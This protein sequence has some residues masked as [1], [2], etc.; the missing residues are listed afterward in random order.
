MRTLLIVADDQTNVH[1]LVDRLQKFGSGFRFRL[2]TADPRVARSWRQKGLEVMIGDPT[3]LL[4]VAQ[5]LVDVEMWY[6]AVSDHV[7]RSWLKAALWVQAHF[8]RPLQ[9]LVIAAVPFAPALTQQ[10]RQNGLQ[11]TFL[12][13]VQSLPS[14]ALIE[15]ADEQRRVARQTMSVAEQIDLVATLLIRPVVATTLEIAN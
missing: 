8:N 3:D 14:G 12:Y 6:L 7:S 5:A 10:L 13:E 9:R 15:I 11:F 4:F 2:A 1:Q